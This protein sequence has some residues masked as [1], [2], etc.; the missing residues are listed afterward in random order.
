L[1]RPRA[2]LDGKNPIVLRFQDGQRMGAN[3]QVISV[4]GGLLSLPKSVDQGSQVKLMFLTEAGS[5]LG[6]AEM[7]PPVS[8]K[9]QPFRFT[10]L[11]ADDQRRV[12]ALVAELSQD[13]YDQAWMDKL[14]A[15]SAAQHEESAFWRFKLAGGIGLVTIGSAIAAYLLHFGLLK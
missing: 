5:V 12:G 6:G 14:R 1:R 8:D 7:L 13:E 2:H 4:T 15:A 9:L 3:L 11:P 10:S